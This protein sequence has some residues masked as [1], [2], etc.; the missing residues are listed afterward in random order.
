MTI[1]TYGELLS[2]LDDMGFIAFGGRTGIPNLAD[3]TRADAW[4]TGRD[5]DPWE[6]KRMLSERRDGIYTRVEGGQA[7]FISHACILSSSPRIRLRCPW[8]N[9][10]KWGR[11]RRLCGKCIACFCD[12]I[13]GPN[14]ICAPARRRRASMARWKG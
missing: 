10:G 7:L 3:V 5:T 8:K 13:P 9:A 14:M 6:W 12:R 4:H 2:L 11:F 1:T